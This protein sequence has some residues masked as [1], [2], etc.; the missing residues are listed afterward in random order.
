[1]NNNVLKKVFPLENCKNYKNLKYDDEGLWSISHP[2][3][4]DNLS[5]KIK[6]FERSGIKI[7]T[8]LDATAGLG[9]NTI[10]FAKFF[11]K[12][13]AVE[14][15]KKRFDFL[16][17]NIENYNFNNIET[18]NKD[19]IE[20]LHDFNEVIDAIFV[21]PPW[22][23][24]NY[25]Y[26]ENLDIKLSGLDLSEICDLIG[27]YSYQNQSIKMIILKLPYN[28]DYLSIINQCKKII[29]VYNIHKDGNVNYLFIMINSVVEKKV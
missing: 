15:D 22:G 17:I 20:S 25:K 3:N 26:D 27:N 18:V 14:I 1:M 4:A 6:L 16:N 2:F 11:N 28:Y 8:I 29:K 9:G 7:N 21:D 19:F 5:K 23:G 12:V 10:S 13:I 24:P